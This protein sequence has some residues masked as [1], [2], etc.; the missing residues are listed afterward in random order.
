RTPRGLG[1]ANERGGEGATNCRRGGDGDATVRETRHAQRTFEPAHPRPVDGFHR[2]HISRRMHCAAGEAGLLDL[3]APRCALAGIEIAPR[4]AEQRAKARGHGEA[5]Y[6]IRDPP[7]H[8]RYLGAKGLNKLSMGL[9]DRPNARARDFTRPPVLRCASRAYASAV[10]DERHHHISRRCR[11]DR[12]ARSS[13]L[14]NNPSSAQSALSTGEKVA[15]GGCR[16]PIVA[17]AWKGEP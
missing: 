6:G 14:G 8:G 10:P 17:F 7:P 5:N 4:A 9:N 12:T 15:A 13:P 3:A 11:K 16:T 1:P 2:C